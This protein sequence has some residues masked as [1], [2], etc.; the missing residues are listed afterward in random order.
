MHIVSEPSILYFG[1]PVILISTTNEDGTFNLA[2]ISSAFWLGWRCVIGIGTNTK[3]SANILRTRECVL[4]LPSV[5]QVDAVDRLAKLTGCNPVPERKWEKGYRYEL[6]KFETANL[7]AMAS[8]IVAAPG[9]RECPVQ[10]EAILAAVNTIADDDEVLKNRIVSYELKIVKI[11]VDDSITVVGD[12]NRIDP[13]KWRPLIMNFQH[14]YGLGKRIHESRLA[15]IP[16]RL[17]K[18][19]GTLP[20][21]NFWF[22]PEV[23]L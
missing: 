5:D 9:V 4:N 7:T 17:Y 13:D 15:Q 6:N 20:S 1:T 21:A 3:T 18:M 11:R 2:P 14:F 16:E 23:L 8:E 22:P 12:V 10:L 19:D